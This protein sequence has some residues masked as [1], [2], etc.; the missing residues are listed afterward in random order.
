V[1]SLPEDS[2]TLPA[3][4]VT[5]FGRFEV[6][7]AG[8]PLALCS[9][10]NG[11][12]VLRYLVAQSEHS[13]TIDTLTALLWPDDDPEVAQGKLYLAISA[14]RRSLNSGYTCEPGYG[15]LVCKSRVYHLN[16]MVDIRTDVDEF[17][18]WHQVGKQASEE[19]AVFYERACGLYKGP[20]LPEDMYADWSF[21][22]RGQLSEMY[23]TMCSVLANHYLAI[24]RYEDAARWA[25]AILKENRCDE[26][27]HRQLIQ[28][29]A[30]QGRRS[31]A[32]RQYQRC[33]RLLRE[34][35]GVQ[36]LPETMLVFQTLLTNE[37]SSNRR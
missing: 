12:A 34:E 29:Y 21:L 10:R 28:I 31:E 5:C 8:K 27:A 23:L 26:T 16:P 22:Q 18:H 6:S 30:A 11:Q 2:T 33:E 13:A 36:P 20:F 4:R 15:Y 37:P 7:R 25:T 19:R 3:L 14:L 17:L 32:L 1:Q 24:K 35:L 9:S